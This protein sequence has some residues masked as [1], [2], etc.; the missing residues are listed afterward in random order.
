M[1]TLIQS[2]RRGFTLLEVTVASTLTAFLGMLLCS[3]WFWI[4]KAGFPGDAVIRGRLL[5]EMDMAVAALSRDLCGSLAIPSSFEP[6]SPSSFSNINQGRWIAWQ[7]P[8]NA[9]LSLC[10]DDE[11]DGEQGSSDIVIRYYLATDPDATVTTGILMREDSRTPG[12]AFA[13]ARH[14]DSL[15]VDSETISGS[16]YV[17]IQLTFKYHLPSNEYTRMITLNARAPQ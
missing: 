16:E 7:H 17:K 11:P 2:R 1:S 3:T 14:V 13:V 8:L 6:A 5:Q 4:G 10:Y 12:A 9:E 15:I